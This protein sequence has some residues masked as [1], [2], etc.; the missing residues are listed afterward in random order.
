MERMWE[1][2]NCLSQ[3]FKTTLRI[4]K[5]MYMESNRKLKTGE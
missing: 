2:I 3:N 1:K 5:Y 4:L